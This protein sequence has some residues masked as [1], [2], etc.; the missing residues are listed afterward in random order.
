MNKVSEMTPVPRD[1]PPGRLN[2]WRPYALLTIAPLCWNKGVEL[3]GANRAGLFINVIPVFASF[4]AVVWLQES[5]KLFHFTGL[6][7]VF[8]GM[9]LFNR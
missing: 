2:N 7:L 3:I 9:V 5:L 1:K 6:L 8:M 4:M